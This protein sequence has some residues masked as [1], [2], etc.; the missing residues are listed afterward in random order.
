MTSGTFAAAIGL[1]L[2]VPK[3]NKNRNNFLI[4]VHEQIIWNFRLLQCLSC[5]K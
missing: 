2:I 3:H 5:D 1:V 4:I